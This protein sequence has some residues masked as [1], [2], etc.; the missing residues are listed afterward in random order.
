VQTAAL[1]PM[2]KMMAL[3]VSLAPLLHHSLTA[4][5]PHCI[6]PSLHHFPTALHNHPCPHLSL[7]LYALIIAS[8]LLLRTL[9]TTHYSTL[10]YST[11]HYTACGAGST[12]RSAGQVRL[13]CSWR[14]D[15]WSDADPAALPGRPLGRH[16]AQVPDAHGQGLGSVRCYMYTCTRVHMYT[17]TC[18]SISLP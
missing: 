14:S 12:S 7:P 8:A 10:H 1:E 18:I 2:Q 9:H 11:L 3:M 4:S 17:C 13:H 6:T 16:E 15:E 5:L